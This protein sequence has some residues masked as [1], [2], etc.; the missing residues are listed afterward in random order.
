MRLLFFTIALFAVCVGLS[1]WVAVSESTRLNQSATWPK[2]DGTIVDSLVR[3]KGSQV[4]RRFCP[5]VIYRYTVAGVLYDSTSV[6]LD[7]DLSQC[8]ADRQ[9]AN[10]IIRPYQNGSAVPVFYD[11]ARP[12]TAT[13]EI[14][15]VPWLKL[16]PKT[17][18]VASFIALMLVVR[19]LRS[20]REPRVPQGK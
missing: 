11:P 17:G 16:Y 1:L 9:W 18:L 3:D 15:K 7:S 14:H 2:T 13:L 19:Q 12:S 8:S 5:Y 10:D 4:H 20:P 6:R